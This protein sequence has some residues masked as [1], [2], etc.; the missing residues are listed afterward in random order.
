ME[1]QTHR[2]DCFTWTTKVA[3]DRSVDINYK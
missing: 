3:G 2:T 1:T